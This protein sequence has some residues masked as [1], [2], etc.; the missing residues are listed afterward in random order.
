MS[1]FLN[2]INLLSSD[3][4]ASLAI[5]NLNLVTLPEDVQALDNLGKAKLL[6][7]FGVQQILN[8]DDTNDRM[9]ETKDSEHNTNYA[10]SIVDVSSMKNKDYKF[11]KKKKFM[12]NKN[13]FYSVSKKFSGLRNEQNQRKEIE[14]I[15]N[16][17]LEKVR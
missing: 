11:I 10:N 15:S 7:P 3:F 2:E 1:N 12:E 5:R 4:N 16:N 13:I 9:L 14:V 17:K 6:L 8:Q